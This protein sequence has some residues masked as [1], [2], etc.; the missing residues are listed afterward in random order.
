[1]PIHLNYTTFKTAWGWCGLVITQ[2]R[3]IRLLLPHSSRHKILQEIHQSFPGA[4]SSIGLCKSTQAQLNRYFSGKRTSFSGKIHI[5]TTR[6][7]N[8]VLMQ[9]CKIPYGHTTTYKSIARKIN[10]PGAARAV[11]NALGYNPL[12]VIIPCHRVLHS[13]STLGGYSGTGGPSFK[14]RLLQLEKNA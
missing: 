4:I 7:T 10:N 3:L 12:P 11:G 6:F 1:M 2:N 9:T 14:N 5:K 13:D 8:A